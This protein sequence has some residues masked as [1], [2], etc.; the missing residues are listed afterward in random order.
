[1]TETNVFVDKANEQTSALETLVGEGKKFQSAEDLA[2]GKLESDQFIEQLKGELA[3]IRKELKNDRFQSE[4]QKELNRGN[5]QQ[6]PA[7]NP[8]KPIEG[9]KAFSPEELS[10]LIKSEIME[11]KQYEQANSN[12]LEADRFITER[13]GNKEKAKQFIV[14]KAAEMGISVNWLLDV[15][16]KSPKALYNVLGL[17]TEPSV[18]KDKTKVVDHVSKVNTERMEFAPKAGV[19]PGSKA[20]FDE[21]RKADKARYFTPEVQNAL[22]KAKKEGLYV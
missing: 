7:A 13:L 19:K 21:I 22:F 6:P 1:M 17:T 14:D 15:A 2:K 5:N 9:S 18:E 3:E 10:S 8:P 11:A 20:Y 12:I 4:L 16:A